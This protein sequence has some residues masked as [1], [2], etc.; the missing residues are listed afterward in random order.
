MGKRGPIGKD[1]VGWQDIDPEADFDVP[2]IPSWVDISPEVELVYEYLTSLPQAQLWGPGTYFQ[3]W[4]TLP[5]LERYL[6]RPGGETLK[7]LTSILGPSL[8]LTEADL[9]RAKVR[10]KE[11]PKEDL[12]MS[13]E[14]AEAMKKVVHMTDRR[15]KL[16]AKA[17]G[18]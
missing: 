11:A 14:E 17:S 7:N 9:E 16:T 13:P 15:A 4:L 5:T 3:L 1:Q 12:A 18:E 8:L 6:G 10:F 2:E